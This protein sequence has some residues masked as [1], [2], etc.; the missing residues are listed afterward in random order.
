MKSKCLGFHAHTSA[1]VQLQAFI[2]FRI[3]SLCVLCSIARSSDKL[4]YIG[5]RKKDR[6]RE[7]NV[8][9]FSDKTKYSLSVN[10]PN[11]HYYSNALT[12]CDRK[13]I[14]YRLKNPI[15]TTDIFSC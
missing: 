9:F 4:I 8:N 1:F 11:G 3:Q 6:E 15:Q 13:R 5:T 7:R 12:Q 2:A 14:K 10:T